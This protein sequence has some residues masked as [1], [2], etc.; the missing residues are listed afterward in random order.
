MAK[1]VIKG[2]EVDRGTAFAKKIEEL[3]G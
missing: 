1:E 2:Y 3:L